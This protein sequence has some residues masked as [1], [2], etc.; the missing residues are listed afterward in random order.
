MENLRNRRQIVDR[1]AVIAGL[2]GIATE[3]APDSAGFRAE[4]LQYLKTILAHGRTVV[5]QRFKEDGDGSVAMRGFTFL[6]DQVIRCIFDF[7]V[8]RIY[9]L[10]NPTSG[11]RLSVIAVG[12]Y[13]RG[14]LAPY[15]D[16]DLLFLFPYKQTPWGEQVVEFMLYM[17]WDLG[18]KVG[19]ATRSIDDCIRLAKADITIRTSILEMRYITGN[20]PL[21]RQLRSR[22]MKEI[23]E[24]SGLD[25][26]EAKLAERDER[27]AR[28]G[29]S[30]YLVEPNIK[31]GKGG[32]RDLHTLF[33]IA[34]Y[35]YR[36]D[37][38]SELVA[39]GVLTA[40]ERR[41]FLKAEDFLKTVRCQLHLIVD[42]AEERLTFDVQP[43]LARRLG[44]K[45]HAGT[46][47]VERFMK[48]YYLVA[49]DVGDL[50][51]IFCAAFEAEQQ[52][53]GRFRM[54]R[55]RFT[56]VPVEG[57]TVDGKRVD[58]AEKVSLK[59]DPVLMIRLFHF[60]QSRD[61]D[62]HPNALR[63]IR[64]NLKLIDNS[65][66]EN[67]EANRMFL[68]MLTSKKDPETTLRRL[69]EAG[70]L[71]R[72]VPDFGRVVAQTQHDMYH[73]YT[74]DEHTIRAIGVLA[75]IES[76]VLGE[77]H[78]L[79][80]DIIHKVLSRR[81]LYVAVLLHDIAKGRGGDHSVIGAEVAET[82]CPRLGLTAAETETVAWLVR[83]H[84][85]FSHFAFKRDIADP[86]T[87][88]NFV[89]I[90]QSPER[91][92]LL[93]VLTVAD[94]RAVGPKVWNG[95]KGQ[96]L[97][98][99][100]YVAESVLSGG[101]AIKGRE[102]RI[103]AS[104]EAFR[105]AMSDWTAEELDRYIAR[106][107]DPYW[108]SLE[109]Q[110]HVRHAHIIRRADRERA[111]LTL[112]NRSDSFRSITE[113]TLYTADHPGLFARIA[114][115]IAIA[116]ANIVGAK[117]FTTADGLALDSFLI[118]NDEGGAFDHPGQLARLSAAIEQT[119]NGTR[120]PRQELADRRN[121]ALP[122]RTRVFT[123]E[124]V[125]LID[126]NASLAHTVIEVNGRDRLGLLAELT[127]AFFD[128]SLSI[129][130]AHIETFGERAVDVFYVKDLFGLKI[131]NQGK[132]KLIEKRL[133]TA[134]TGTVEKKKKASPKPAA[135]KE[136]QA[137]E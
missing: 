94:I 58:M 136:T 10:T 76:G 49:K 85:V 101:H 109:T 127:L 62:I 26:V 80:N 71:G 5:E 30:R 119:L 124:P 15:S 110:A 48:H 32:L 66:R 45:D 121:S 96:L 98:E 128:L 2:D 23:V 134:L 125:V 126:N 54:P 60:A 106:H 61:L 43:E 68:E 36:A 104:K 87:V 9:R 40:A 24:G 42:R 51:R 116:G 79:S 70:V 29:D 34:K 46:L 7:T 135:G 131:T 111:P 21:E 12:G 27:H 83:Y 67:P 50:T 105:E 82:L 100:Y 33:W 81:V 95:W 92:R 57:L 3:H 89:N 11:E 84:L 37:E 93:L 102:A 69:S 107:Y 22:F 39:R 41:R 90:V 14:E 52:G 108:L 115:A 132:L 86:K 120:R 130:S 123:V 53:R 31:E 73:V 63:I 38:V 122:S 55:F 88:E 77:D 56:K 133:L 118:Q 44:Y 114:G 97:R 91:L 28:L 19:H 8:G 20:R 17:L 25:F 4:A 113:I 35:L 16:V 74:V 112:E 65:V 18:L 6:T 59:A 64:R 129:S 78:P 137:A 75:R 103:R 117:I 47:G 99:L 13:G 72:F 1:K